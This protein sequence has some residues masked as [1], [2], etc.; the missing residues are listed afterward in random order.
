L[1]LG[2]QGKASVFDSRPDAVSAA[3]AAAGTT[4]VILYENDLPDH[5]P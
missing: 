4:G 5:Y 1:L 2:A 3:L